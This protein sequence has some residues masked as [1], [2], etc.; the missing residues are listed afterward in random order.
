MGDKFAITVFWLIASS[1]IIFG[2]VALIGLPFR[3]LELWQIAVGAAGAITLI[4]GLR[5]CVQVLRGKR[6]VGS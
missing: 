4:F 1:L 6:H 2:L 3:S 5:Q